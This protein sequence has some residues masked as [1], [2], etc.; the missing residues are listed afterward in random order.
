MDITT[1]VVWGQTQQP[2]ARI[3]HECWWCSTGIPTRGTGRL[4]KF[5]SPRCRARWAKEHRSG[6]NNPAWRGGK[7]TESYPS[8]FNTAFKTVIRERDGYTCVLC[9]GDGKEVHHLDYVKSHTTPENCVTLCKPC[10]GT[11]NHNRSHWEQ[12]LSELVIER[13][14]A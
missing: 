2:G 11:T 6:S 1:L 7:A 12:V 8:T 3:T 5:C 13:D 10:H 14:L 9:G 4:K